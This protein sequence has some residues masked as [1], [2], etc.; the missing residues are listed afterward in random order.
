MRI[1]KWIN[2]HA[3]EILLVAMLV[4]MLVIEILQIFMRRVMGA[5]LSWAEEVVRYLFGLVWIPQYQFHHTKSVCNA[6]DHAGSGTAQ[7]GASCL[8]RSGIY[9]A[10]RVFRVYFCGF[11]CAAW[12]NASDKCCTR[13][14]DGVCISG[15]GIGVCFVSSPLYQALVVVFRGFGKGHDHDIIIDTKPEEGGVNG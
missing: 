14:A 2:R 9:H 1:I 3:E 12:L 15:A 5:S 6:S 7:N 10:D 13:Y 11:Y 8:Y 4:A